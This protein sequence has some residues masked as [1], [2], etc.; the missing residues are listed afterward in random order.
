VG[1]SDGGLARGGPVAKLG[2]GGI[3]WHTRAHGGILIF[4][5]LLLGGYLGGGR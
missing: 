1:F 4:W 2:R 5:L 3:C